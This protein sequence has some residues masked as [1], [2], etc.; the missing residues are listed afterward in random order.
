LRV[1]WKRDRGQRQNQETDSAN[2]GELLDTSF[3]QQVKAPFECAN[4]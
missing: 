4:E 1:R 2:H 3:M